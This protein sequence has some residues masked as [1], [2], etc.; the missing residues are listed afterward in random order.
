MEGTEQDFSIV[1]GPVALD[2]GDL[3]HKRDKNILLMFSLPL[4]VL[5]DRAEPL[6]F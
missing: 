6:S 2:L 3:Q 1:K 4:H 5:T